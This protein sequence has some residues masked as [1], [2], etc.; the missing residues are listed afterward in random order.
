MKYQSLLFGII[1]AIFSII[2]V[3]A[4]GSA[5][6]ILG[7]NYNK[8][9]HASK[10]AVFFH[11]ING[12]IATLVGPLQFIRQIRSKW[13]FAHRWNGRFYLLNLILCYGSAIVMIPYAANGSIGVGLL[14]G[15]SFLYMVL[16]D[17]CVLQ[18]HLVFSL[19][20]CR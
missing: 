1:I 10:I 3:A 2:V 19:F 5:Q 12:G 17:T 13:P 14:Q 8:F 4:A 7:I 9:Q 15:P 16:L 11:V 6:Y 20:F 18:I